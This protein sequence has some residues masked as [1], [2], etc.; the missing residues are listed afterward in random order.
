MADVPEDS[1]DSI[2]DPRGCRDGRVR[3]E[4]RTEEATRP[5]GNNSDKTHSHPSFVNISIRN[6]IGIHR[7]DIA[8]QV[9]GRETMDKEDIGSEA[10][11]IY[12]ERH[13]SDCLCMGCGTRSLCVCHV[14]KSTDGTDGYRMRELI[15]GCYSVQSSHRPPSLPGR[16]ISNCTMSRRQCPDEVAIAVD[17]WMNNDSPHRSDLSRSDS[18]SGPGHAVFGAR[19]TRNSALHSRIGKGI[20]LPSQLVHMLRSD[21]IKV[22]LRYR[23]IM[24]TIKKWIPRVRGKKL[25]RMI[26]R[27]LR[28][29]LQAWVPP[30]SG[31]YMDAQI[32]AAGG[33]GWH[34][35]LR[36]STPSLDDVSRCLDNVNSSLHIRIATED[37]ELSLIHI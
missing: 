14:A 15:S 31:D 35:W 8:E 27:W 6:G 28:G 19:V 32:Q 18:R 30:G 22:L 4:P 11:H 13:K 9:R 12:D 25:R 10:H 21:E 16:Q 33:W 17:S 24:M 2:R 7:E 36:I 29:W 34:T 37:Q 5:T 23:D 26:R 1:R 3:G 20:L